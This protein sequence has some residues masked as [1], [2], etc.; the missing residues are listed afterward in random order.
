MFTEAWLWVTNH[1]LWAAWKTLTRPS[2][3]ATGQLKAHCSV[4]LFCFHIPQAVRI[5]HLHTS[6]IVTAFSPY[7]A[8]MQSISFKVQ[9]LASQSSLQFSQARFLVMRQWKPILA[10][11]T[12]E[13][14]SWRLGV[15]CRILRRA[16]VCHTADLSGENTSTPPVDA[17][18]S[19]WHC[20]CDRCGQFQGRLKLD[21][22]AVATVSRE[23][24]IVQSP[25][26]FAS[27]ASIPNPGR[28]YQW[29][30]SPVFMFYLQEGVSKFASLVPSGCCFPL[31]PKC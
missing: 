27:L 12:R 2:W 16:E 5:S 14:N 13:R 15:A 1:S 20:L 30:L 9:F 26:S 29:S 4:W 3:V 17:G 11:V 31:G 25:W 21:L 7:S 6:W 8:R 19:S 23:K 24:V 22:F 28:A 10:N 18:F